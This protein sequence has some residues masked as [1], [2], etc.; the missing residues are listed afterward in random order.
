MGFDKWIVRS[1]EY[2]LDGKELDGIFNLS[3]SLVVDI[4][5]TNP[6]L[7]AIRHYL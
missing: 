1:E 5:P 4:Q 3:L 2:M 6:G 7:T